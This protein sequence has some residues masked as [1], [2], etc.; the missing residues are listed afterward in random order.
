MSTSSSSSLICCARCGAKDV[1]MAGPL[2][3]NPIV[4]CSICAAPLWRW[5]EFVDLMRSAPDAAPTSVHFSPLRPHK[6]RQV[7]SEAGG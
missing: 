7:V 4:S 6:A 1:R 2:R 5:S 3:A